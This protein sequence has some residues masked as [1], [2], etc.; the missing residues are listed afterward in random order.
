MQHGNLSRRGFLQCVQGALAGAGLPAWYAGGLL[1]A[2]EEGAAKQTPASD[3]LVM[4]IVGIGSPESRSL[5]VV[6]ESRPC[7]KSGQLTFT[8]GCDVDAAHRKRA[9]EVMRERGFRDF[10]A[11]TK[12]FRELIHN[13]SVDCLLVT[14]PDH[15]H[16]QVAIEALRAGKDVY[17]EKPLTLTVAESLV[18]QKVVKETG[19]ILQTGSQQRTDYGGM[20]RLAV[21]LV[22]AGRLGK[23]NTIE[24]RIGGNPTSGPIPEAPVPEGL[25][26]DLWLGP[27]A[28]VPYR[29]KGKRSNCHY[30]FR[31]WYDYSGGKMTDWGAHHLDIAQWALGK[32]GSGPVAV[33]VLK[34]D[35]PYKGRDGYNGHP[36]FHV[37]YS[38]DNGTKV[39]A[40]DGG[41]TDAKSLVD[42]D[43]KARKATGRPQ[44]EWPSDP[45]RERHDL[46]RP[47]LAPC[48]RSQDPFRA[49]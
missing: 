47:R 9:T 25:D 34:A 6:G 14:T 23:I 27:T 40:M 17:C 12:D 42:K 1:A 19:H 38:Y 49:A 36:H 39:I 37:Q 21:E 7:V 11:K 24:C 29:K 45:G 48:Q 35:E 31:W 41:G 2:Q 46:C 4:G 18:L 16:A 15:W 44:L 32:D 13:P 28:K 33:E 22:R 20:F 43:G 26:W 30:E 3:R 10:E 8:L 5:Q